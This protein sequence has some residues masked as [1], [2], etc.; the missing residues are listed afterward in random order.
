MSL[1]HVPVELLKALYPFQREGV[2]FGL[3]KRGR[4]LIGDEMGLGKTLQGLALAAAYRREWPVLV[5]APT[6]M[7]LQWA[8][9]VEKWLPCVL[10]GDINLV[11]SRDN[12]RLATAPVSIIS[13]GKPRRQSGASFPMRSTVPKLPDLILAPFRPAR[14]DSRSV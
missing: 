7:C 13:Y 6:S 3:G 5:V 4:V 12:S 10:P 1:E 14:F 8:D 2:E 11:L 9:E